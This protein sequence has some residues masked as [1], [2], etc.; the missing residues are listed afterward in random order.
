MRY[1]RSRSSDRRQTY[2]LTAASDRSYGTA[3]PPHTSSSRAGAHWGVVVL[4]ATSWWHNMSSGSGA[5]TLLAQVV[6]QLTPLQV[7]HM[8]QSICWTFPHRTS[9][10]GKTGI[11]L[12]HAMAGTLGIR[13]PL[14]RA[15]GSIPVHRGKLQIDARFCKF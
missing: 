6:G 5:T 4:D 2:F 1:C 8:P 11:W 10:Q 9:S 15:L 7:C 13:K 14:A 3:A 12:F